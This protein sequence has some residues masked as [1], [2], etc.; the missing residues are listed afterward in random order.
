MLQTSIARLYEDNAARLGLGWVT[1]RGGEALPV[2]RDSAD[3]AALVGHLNLIHPNRIQVLGRRELAYIDG[4]SGDASGQVI[5]N[6]FAAEPA[7]IILADSVVGPATLLRSAEARSVPVL[8]TAAAADAVIDTLRRYLAKILADST[9]MHGVFM[10]VL[11]L[12]VLITGESGV[13]KSE[14]ALE[15]SLANLYT[16]INNQITFSCNA[17]PTSPATLVNISL[18]HNATGIL[19][20]NQTQSRTGVTNAST[21]NASFPFGNYNWSC[22]ACDSDGDCGVAVENRSL[23]VTSAIINS[24]NY[25]NYTTSGASENFIVNISYNPINIVNVILNYNNTQYSMTTSNNQIYSTSLNVPVVTSSINKSF[26]IGIEVTSGSETTTV[27]SGLYNQTIQ[28]FS[29]DNCTIYKQ[30]ILHFEMVDEELFNNVA[31]PTLGYIN[32]TIQ[33]LI[34]FYSQ[35]RTK[36]ISTFNNSINYTYGNTYEI[37]IQNITSNYSM[38]YQIKYPI[39][40][41]TWFNK[42]K[43]AQNKIINNATLMENVTLYNLFIASGNTFQIYVR[44][45]NLGNS[46]LLVDVQKQYVAKNA[47]FS[48]ESPVTDNTGNTIARL[49]QTSEIYNFIVSKNGNILGIFNNYQVKCANAAT[50]DCPITLNLAEQTGNIVNLE[51]YGNVTGIHLLNN[52]TNTLYYTFQTTDSNAHN[53]RQQVIINDGFDN[54]TIC[55]QTVL[56]VSGTIICSIP[57]I[58]QETTF[59]AKI[60]SD[61]NLI[62]AKLFS[63]GN[64]PDFYGVEIFM[65]VLLYSS[66]VLLMLSNPILIVLGTMLGMIF[67]AIILFLGSFKL[68]SIIITLSYFIVAGVIIINKMRKTY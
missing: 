57:T 48:V 39:E 11:G 56:A 14:L 35:D 17:T 52:N 40:D 42:Y 7:A 36:L 53:I 31:N 61:G 5:A 10:D 47:F 62:G 30:K 44:G 45:S 68:T 63:Q 67:S 15:L 41:T 46:G 59:Y 43:N 32:G 23:S 29:V 13:G 38:D 25:N 20:I 27:Y 6:L 54:Q 34:N 49:I 9:S 22:S 58:Y 2:R 18:L 1:G 28:P 50:G 19:S 37:C 26:Y 51:N 3:T 16:T 66:I 60:Y 12:G 64:K 24:I 65:S 33:Y 4:Y 8:A 55:D 21:F